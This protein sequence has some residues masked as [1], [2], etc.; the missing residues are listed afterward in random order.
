[1]PREINVESSVKSK[2]RENPNSHVKSQCPFSSI[3][4][5]LHRLLS[6]DPSFATGPAASGLASI[7]MSK[8][9]PEICTSPGVKKRR[10]RRRRRLLGIPRENG[11][12]LVSSRCFCSCLSLSLCRSHSLPPSYYIL[13]KRAWHL[14]KLDGAVREISARG[15][16]SIPS[17]QLQV[18]STD[19]GSE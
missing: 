6:V 1:M 12:E 10:R 5:G 18:T 3:A 2:V 13:Q 8:C 15:N 4:V 17:H 14:K 16:G 7:L 11:K 19:K 9:P